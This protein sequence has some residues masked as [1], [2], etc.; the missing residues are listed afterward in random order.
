MSCA[1]KYIQYKC[2]VVF[3]IPLLNL[4]SAVLCEYTRMLFTRII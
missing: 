2:F 1:Y 3:P 4:D